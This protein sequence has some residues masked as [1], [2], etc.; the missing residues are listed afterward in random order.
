MSAAYLSKVGTK[1]TVHH[2][3]AQAL[4]DPSLEGRVVLLTMNATELG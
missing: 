1:I 3:V 4:E 2:L